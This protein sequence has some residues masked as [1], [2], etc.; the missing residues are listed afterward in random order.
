MVFLDEDAKEQKRSQDNPNLIEDWTRAKIDILAPGITTER[1]PDITTVHTKQQLENLTKVKA[2][3]AAAEEIAFPEQDFLKEQLASTIMSYDLRRRAL[4]KI[5]VQLLHE[6]R[7]TDPSDIQIL[8]EA[9]HEHYSLRADIYRA[10]L[11]KARGYYAAE[12]ASAKHAMSLMDTEEQEILTEAALFLPT[13]EADEIYHLLSASEE[14][15]GY[16]D[17]IDIFKSKKDKLEVAEYMRLFQVPLSRIIEV[18]SSDESSL[19]FLQD[20]FTA[21][22]KLP[23]KNTR[24]VQMR[25]AYLRRHLTRENINKLNDKIADKKAFAEIMGLTQVGIESGYTHLQK[26]FEKNLDDARSFGEDLYNAWHLAKEQYYTAHPE[27]DKDKPLFNV[28]E[29]NTLYEELG[30]IAKNISS[31]NDLQ[32]MHQ[33]R[34][35]L[36]EEIQ[37][38]EDV[39]TQNKIMVELLQQVDE[40]LAG[41]VRQK[42]EETIRIQSEEID[43]RLQQ[44]FAV[45]GLNKDALLAY[46]DDPSENPDDSSGMRALAQRAR[47]QDAALKLANS[48]HDDLQTLETLRQLEDNTVFVQYSDLEQKRTDVPK[49]DIENEAIPQEVTQVISAILFHAQAA[50]EDAL[51]N[52]LQDYLLFA[53]KWGYEIPGDGQRSFAAERVLAQPCTAL[54][55][56][57]NQGNLIKTNSFLRKAIEQE[58]ESKSIEQYAGAVQQNMFYQD[59]VRLKSVKAAAVEH[60]SEQVKQMTTSNSADMAKIIEGKTIENN[61]IHNRFEEIRQGYLDLYEIEKTDVEK[62]YDKFCDA[63]H[64]SEKLAE[65]HRSQQSEL[66]RK[67]ASQNSEDALTNDEKEQLK[68]E[69]ELSAYILNLD[70]SCDDILGALDDRKADTFGDVD[71]ADIQ[72]ILDARANRLAELQV[73]KQQTPNAFPTPTQVLEEVEKYGS[74]YGAERIGLTEER[75]QSLAKKGVIEVVEDAEWN[76]SK[77]NVQATAEGKVRVKASEWRKSASELKEAGAYEEINQAV[78]Q[79]QLTQKTDQ[80]KTEVKEQLSQLGTFAEW[81]S[82][83][84]DVDK[85]YLQN[86]RGLD[87][88]PIL[89]IV[90]HL[91][92]NENAHF[93]VTETGFVIRVKRSVWEGNQEFL[94]KVLRHEGLHA[95]DQ[96]SKYRPSEALYEELKN[97]PGFQEFYNKFLERYRRMN[98]NKRLPHRDRKKEFLAYVFSDSLIDPNDQGEA[99]ELAAFKS[100]NQTLLNQFLTSNLVQAAQHFADNSVRAGWW[101]AGERLAYMTIDEDALVDDE[102]SEATPKT[103]R[104]QYNQRRR[105]ILKKL[106]TI[107]KFKA[108]PD[109]FREQ[110][111]SNAEGTIGVVS[112]TLSRFD[113]IP[114]ENRDDAFTQMMAM[115]KEAEKEIDKVLAHIAFNH[116]EEVNP[117][118]DLWD[119][120]TFLALGDFKTLFSTTK[121]FIERRHERNSKRRAGL[122]GKALFENLIPPLGNEFDNVREK[123]ETDAV[124]SYKEQLSN[125]DSWQIMERVDSSANTDELKACL[126]LLSERGA[127]D[128]NDRRLWRAFERYQNHIRFF[129][130]DADNGEFLRSKFQRACGILYDNDFFRDIDRKNASSFESTK[131]EYKEESSQNMDHMDDIITQMIIDK[132]GGQKKVS[133][134]RFEMYIDAAI[135]LNKSNPIKVFWFI[136]Q[137]VNLGLLNMER[138][139]QFDTKYQNQYPMTN[140]FLS[141][142]P[143][144]DQLRQIGNMFKPKEDGDMPANFKD[145]FQTEVIG[146]MQVQERMRKSC[147]DTKLDHDWAFVAGSVGNAGIAQMLLAT[148]VGTNGRLPITGIPNVIAGQLFRITTMA[149][150]SKAGHIQNRELLREQV[151]AHIEYTFAFGAIYNGRFSHPKEYGNTSIRDTYEGSATERRAEPREKAIYC[152]KPKT[153]NEFM[154][155]N[156]DIIKVLDPE[157]FRIIDEGER[158]I[159]PETIQKVRAHLTAAHGFTDPSLLPEGSVDFGKKIGAI[160]NEIMIKN[161]NKLD[162]IL[163]AAVGEYQKDHPSQKPDDYLNTYTYSTTGDLSTYIE[164]YPKEDHGILGLK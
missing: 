91:P 129:E 118:T 12:Y 3:L 144:A 25:D 28:F 74:A 10:F 37:D 27:I 137:G 42:S 126:Y 159:T 122:V 156:N 140:W 131:Q 1:A 145:W 55:E 52:P 93:E 163:D 4:A 31:P 81:V 141:V 92:N 5:A 154:K 95:I 104:F 32:L 54:A 125:K 139:T 105:R 150:E 86:L 100:Q 123:S 51:K 117:L 158:V 142:K 127:I 21:L 58:T 19:E 160:A 107:R 130:S 128:W 147:S 39:K 23:Y 102:L 49:N 110:L 35:E 67:A 2:I 109:D 30:E 9:A 13:A 88:K 90:D 138:V 45:H 115:L 70:A 84:R 29:A 69:E 135:N 155:S 57:L 119:N 103:F 6:K 96:A 143:T 80:E 50:Q 98:G 22:A 97:Q 36:F 151:A 136:L 162:E 106:Q 101:N 78:F 17:I 47:Y 61:E 152:A 26:S 121:E 114:K 146:N 43:A 18:F 41:V 153:T 53:E 62:W 68:K 108:M 116:S 157:L 11:E 63:K 24:L 134:H 38:S 132:R 34:N 73:K 124:N 33:K 133:P 85:E 112:D 148:N 79:K 75:K 111:I 83:H 46:Q 14:L 64:I 8:Y 56:G 15:D 40:F 120:T 60:V 71:R 7:V 48:N 65:M 76:N 99:N 72:S 59:F 82:S 20:F 77:T 161:P 16:S 149:R 94:A 44:Q 89:E 66:A 87:H 113:S 164:G